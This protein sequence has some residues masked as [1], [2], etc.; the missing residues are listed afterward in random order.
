MFLSG[1]AI[2]SAANMTNGDVVRL[3]KGGL[4]NETITMSIQAAEPGFDLSADGLLALKKENVPP[5]VIKAMLKATQDA[6]NERMA[7]GAAPTPAMP[8]K[9]GPGPRYNPEKIIWVHGTEQVYMKYII[10]TNRSALRALGWGGF[11]T[12]MVLSGPSA[13]QRISDRRPDFVV[14]VPENAQPTS[15]L[16]LA[17]FAVRT[18]GTREVM[19]GGGYGSYSTGITPDRIVQTT[20]EKVESQ[21]GCPTGFILYRVK[22]ARALVPGEYGLVVN[23]SQY[24]VAGFFANVTNSCFDFGID[25]ASN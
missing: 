4:D 1:A 10:P 17:S 13:V 19:V 25:F 8:S 23:N 24:Q 18:N 21:D 15:Y 12:Y 3:V 22:P 20:A 6:R 5:A 14:A 9:E 11:A 16:T 2:A 7:S